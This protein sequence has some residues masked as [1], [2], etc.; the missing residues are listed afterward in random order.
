MIMIKLLFP[1]FFNLIFLKTDALELNIL[2]IDKRNFR[3]EYQLTNHSKDEVTINVRSFGNQGFLRLLLEKDG[4]KI[5]FPCDIIRPNFSQI[6]T[7]KKNFVCI[8]SGETK[9][10]E[11]KLKGCYMK[12]I[13]L[14]EGLYKAK[15]VYHVD[16]KAITYAKKNNLLDKLYD[17]KIESDEFDLKL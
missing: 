17:L 12:K 5:K 10:M 8:K 15:L 9:K 13:S 11:L 3:V 6:L 16:E 4:K 14:D 2:S 1:L 7:D